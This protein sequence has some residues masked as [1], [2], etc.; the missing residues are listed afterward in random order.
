MIMHAEIR[1]ACVQVLFSAVYHLKS[2]I[3]PYSAD[4]LKVSL[5]VLREGSEKVL[6]PSLDHFTWHLEL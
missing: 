6:N 2:A 3:L 4:L 1:A 5:K